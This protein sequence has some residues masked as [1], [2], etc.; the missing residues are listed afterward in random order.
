MVT[1]LVMAVVIRNHASGHEISDFPY[2][3]KSLV[4]VTT[5]KILVLDKGYDA[6]WVH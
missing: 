6:E 4:G 2:L 3:L 5:P 1:Q